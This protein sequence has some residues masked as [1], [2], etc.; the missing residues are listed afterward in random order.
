MGALQKLMV[1]GWIGR[2][3]GRFNPP[4]NVEVVSN[5]SGSLTP[6]ALTVKPLFFDFQIHEQ[7]RKWIIGLRDRIYSS[8]VWFL[9]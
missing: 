7:Q 5:F 8:I 9:P 1:T 3:L 2:P 4:P 6:P